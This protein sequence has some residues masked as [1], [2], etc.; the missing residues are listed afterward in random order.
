MKEKV[1]NFLRKHKKGLIVL[2]VLVILVFVVLPA[3]V[4]KKAGEMMDSLY[5]SE[6]PTTEDL[7]VTLTGTGTI[8]PNDQYSIMSM[9]Q[10]EI[11]DAPFEAG[12]VVE[13]GQV[14]YQFSTE[15][16]EDSIRSA[17]IGVEQAQQSYNEAVDAKSKNDED[18]SLVSD[19]DG[20]VKK[21]YVEKG[22]KITAGTKIADLYDNTTM[23]AE[24]PFNASDVESSW[25]GNR[26]RVYV[27]DEGERVNGTVTAID[28]TTTTLSGNMV[29]RYVTIEVKNPGG[30]ASGMTATAS[31]GG[32]DC[33]S[34]GVFEVISEGTLI[35]DAGGT[36]ESLKIKKGTRLKKGDVYLRL[37][38]ATISDSVKSSEL[39]LENAQNQLNT[40]EKN[41]DDYQVTAPISGTVITKN[42]KAGDN[43][44]A[45]YA[46]PLAVIYD[47]SK[48]KFQM[49]V[50]ELDVLKISVGQEV[51]VTADALEGV[52]MT[53]HITTI[54]LE[55]I[56]TG[57]VTE[58][59]V[60]VELDEVGQLLPGMNVSATIVLDEKKDAMCIPVDALMRGNLVY[61]RN[62]E[63]EKTSEE[64]LADGVPEGFHKVEVTVGISS[65]SKVQILDGLSTT[66]EVYVPRA[67]STDMMM[68]MMTERQNMI[69]NVTGEE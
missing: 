67:E 23:T 16:A 18:R 8:E 12:D 56:T 5:Q 30:I 21:L 50:D 53:G 33:N 38:D 13:K 47:L 24:I 40:A 46:S 20:Y 60:T 25:I 10:G 2:V 39:N 69:D 9:V 55:A 4:Q 28:P 32:V 44:N 14:L 1:L 63:G 68:R 17:E 54:S 35:A 15:N 58:Y 61:V 48:V 59:P 3:V 26:A 57:G 6:Q 49:K 37:K 31:I 19:Q 34:A 65:D 64:E 36:I 51:S 45:T 7:Q 52:E 62:A 43:I 41:L 11:T 29:V 27:G 22:Q 42:A 66:D